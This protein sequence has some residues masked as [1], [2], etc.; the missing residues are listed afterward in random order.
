MGSLQG[1]AAIKDNQTWYLGGN[2]WNYDPNMTISITSDDM[3]RFILLN[4]GTGA[5][6]GMTWDLSPLADGK[7]WGANNQPLKVLQ[8]VNK[9]L[10]PVRST[11]CGIQPSHNWLITNSVDWVKAPAFVAGRSLDNRKEYIHVIKPPADRFIDLPKPLESFRSAR[12]YLSK[13]PVKMALQGDVLRLTLP[14]NEKWSEL[15]TVIE[16]T[17]KK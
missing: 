2:W 4:V 14:D 13:R 12:L 6:G 15:D 7:T 5:P 17:V 1:K 9:L 10:A 16:L 8:G 11:V 3:Y